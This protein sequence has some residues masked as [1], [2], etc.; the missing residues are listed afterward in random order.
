MTA[1]TWSRLLIAG[2]LLGMIGFW[3]LIILSGFGFLVR[4]R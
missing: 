2:Y 1:V 4:S 3:G